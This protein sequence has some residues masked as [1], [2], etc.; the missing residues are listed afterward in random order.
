MISRALIMSTTSTG[1][2]RSLSGTVHLSVSHKVPP[3]VRLQTKCLRLSRHERNASVESNLRQLAVGCDAMLDVWRPSPKRRLV[4]WHP[5]EAG[6]VPLLRFSGPHSLTQK[7]A[8]CRSVHGVIALPAAMVQAG[9]AIAQMGRAYGQARGEAPR[10][11][12]TAAEPAF[13]SWMPRPCG[14]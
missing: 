4:A 7:S 10:S 9:R 2:S 1:A 3:L 6:S 13:G 12:G 14:S 8:R 5:C 11:R